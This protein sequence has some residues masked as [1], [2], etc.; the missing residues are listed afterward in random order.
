MEILEAIT[1]EEIKD[2]FPVLKTLRVH[3]NDIS[4]FLRRVLSQQ[5]AGYHLVYLKDNNM[6]QA[7]AG[8]RI[9]E[10][11]ETSDPRLV[12]A[13]ILTMHVHNNTQWPCPQWVS[14]AGTCMW[15]TW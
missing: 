13:L 6:V 8:Y 3:F 14:C 1:E 10:H 7:I 2:C 11:L 5:K 4:D 15:L 9:R 12:L